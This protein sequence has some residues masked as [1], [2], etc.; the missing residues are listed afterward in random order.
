MFS[1]VSREIGEFVVSATGG[2]GEVCSVKLLGTGLKIYRTGNSPV[3]PN[4]NADVIASC[5]M[6][7]GEKGKKKPDNEEAMMVV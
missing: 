2:A 5:N 4:G 6:L 3:H 1:F 7:T